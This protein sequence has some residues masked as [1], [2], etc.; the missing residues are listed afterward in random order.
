[1]IIKPIKTRIFKEGEDLF[2][3]ITAHIKK[4]PEESVIVITSKIVALAERRTV[5]KENSS[6]KEKLIK[7]ESEIAI[8]SKYVWLTVLQGTIMASAGIDESNAN[9]K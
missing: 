5:T 2:D 6:T 1:M 3:F 4:I 7:R 9:G 8:P